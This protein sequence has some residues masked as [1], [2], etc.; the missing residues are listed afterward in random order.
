MQNCSLELLA[1]ILLAG[2]CCTHT[3]NKQRFFAISVKQNKHVLY[4]TE[5]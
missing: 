5:R 1:A 4:I 3:G 2:V